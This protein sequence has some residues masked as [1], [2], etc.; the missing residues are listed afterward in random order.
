MDIE[1]FK[2]LAEIIAFEC[3]GDI[4]KLAEFSKIFYEDYKHD[5]R[6]FIDM[7]AS[8]GS[9]T[10]HMGGKPVKGYI[11]NYAMENEDNFTSFSGYSYV[12]RPASFTLRIDIKGSF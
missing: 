5:T 3:R 11:S 10:L 8:C 4:S 9:V 7:D 2:T 12:K 6:T 1:T